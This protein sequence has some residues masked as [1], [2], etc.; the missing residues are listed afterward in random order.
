MYCQRHPSQDQ[1]DGG[2]YSV[3]SNC[4]V[5]STTTIIGF[6]PLPVSMRIEPTA[7]FSGAF[8][9][10]RQATATAV[11]SG[12]V[13][14]DAESS[15]SGIMLSATVGSTALTVGQGGTLSLNNDAD[16]HMILD[17]EL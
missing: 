10:R 2:A 12:P 7:S 13:I 11:S 4:F 15:S 14:A 8:R 16:A 6:L 3:I 9:V 1:A 17:A 5:D